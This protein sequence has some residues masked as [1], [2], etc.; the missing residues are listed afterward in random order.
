MH[1]AKHITICIFAPRAPYFWSNKSNTTADYSCNLSRLA[2]FLYNYGTVPNIHDLVGLVAHTSCTYSRIILYLFCCKANK[3]WFCRSHNI[4]GNIVRSWRFVCCIEYSSRNTRLSIADA[5]CRL[6]SGMLCSGTLSV[7][8]KLDNDWLF[9]V[10]GTRDR[11]RDKE[12]YFGSRQ[13]WDTWG[14]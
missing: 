9:L 7:C 3:P 4:F 1:I 14:W 8:P 11:R 13:I 6:F 12:N 2:W 5:R 10:S